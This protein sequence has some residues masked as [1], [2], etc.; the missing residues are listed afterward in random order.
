MGHPSSGCGPIARCRCCGS[1]SSA[2]L[3]T[4]RSQT[5]PLSWPKRRR[6]SHLRGACESRVCAR[7]RM[8]RCAAKRCEG[9]LHGRVGAPVA[10]LLITGARAPSTQPNADTRFSLREA[11]VPSLDE[12]LSATPSAAF[13]AYRLPRCI[14]RGESISLHLHQC[15]E[16]SALHPVGRVRCGEAVALAISPRAFSTFPC[17]RFEV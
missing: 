15:F 4:C 6:S 3:E 5:R 8:R 1:A 14:G 7:I 9:R 2:T 13:Y 16:W 17:V 10:Q 12:R 11:L